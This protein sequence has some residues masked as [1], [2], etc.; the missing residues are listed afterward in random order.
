[1]TRTVS[2][3]FHEVEGMKVQKLSSG[4]EHSRGK[5]GPNKM[6][7]M[8]VPRLLLSMAAPMML[9]MIVQALYNV[10]DSLFVSYIPDTPELLHAGD[11][12]VNALTLA[13]PIQMLIMA[14][15]V[16]TGVG[17]NASLARSLGGGDR[18]QAGRIA[19]NAMVLSL[20]YYL[21]MLAF[22]LLGAHAYLE[23]QTSDPVVLKFSFSYLSIITIYSFG[24]IGYMCFEKLLQAT[25]KTTAAM[26]GQLVGS[27][28]NIILDPVFIF[29]YFGVPAMGVTGAAVA[30]II[31]QCASFVVI[32]L[33]HF[34]CNREV[35]FRLALLRPNRKIIFEIYRV[36]GPA[37][38]M[39][40]LTSVMTYGMNLI[41]GS[42]SA[43][44]VTAYGVYYK[45]QNFI[46]MPAYG[47]NNASVPILS[48]NYGAKEAGRIR[49]AIRWGLGTVSV[50]MTAGILL[51]Q[52]GARP[53]VQCFALSE[54]AVELCV[55]ALR[56]I[57]LGFL[58]AGAN[59]LLQ[60]V[61]QALGNGIYSLIISLI[62]MVI[63]VLPLAF[64]LSHLP[65]AETWVWMAFPISELSACA[66]AAWLAI[67]LFHK[68]LD[69]LQRE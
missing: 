37:I 14:L 28:T 60:G 35:P 15:C 26:T 46:F 45:L 25:G 16:G 17:I 69:Q 50:I 54:E 64:F 55:T 59:I 29:G 61:C 19:G 21:V 33:L 24:T 48:F 67:R 53:I 5:V 22:G 12:A 56:I 18:E 66:V 30:T 2:T 36:G 38:V 7:S 62:R 1:M 44:A 49:Q 42:V 23:S 57:T 51:L 40:S 8:P 3:R 41:L 43:T 9:S 31:G 68:C 6:G 10:V 63:V 27:L 34:C 47:L 32:T 65:G 4:A 58:F 11:M 13:F 52:L 20:G 39:Q